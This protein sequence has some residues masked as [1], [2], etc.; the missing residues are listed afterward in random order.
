M[1]WSREEQTP[2]RLLGLL[3]EAGDGFVVEAATAIPGIVVRAVIDVHHLAQRAGATAAPLV[4][5]IHVPRGHQFV[6]AAAEEEHRHANVGDEALGVPTVAVQAFHPP[7][8][9]REHGVDHVIDRG[10]G[11]LHNDAADDVRIL[12]RQPQRHCAADRPAK[13]V[14]TPRRDVRPVTAAG[15]A[16]LQGSASILLDAALG[17]RSLG[18]AVAAVTHHEHVARTQRHHAAGST[19]VPPAPRPPTDTPATSV[20]ACRPPTARTRPR[21]LI[22]QSCSAIHRTPGLAAAAGTTA[23]PEKRTTRRP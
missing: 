19:A 15:H 8:H 7:Q 5:D 20:S 21:S 17:R 1:C 9:P 14:Q 10:E 6:A 2:P 16:V 22:P 13:H 18:H 4:Q 12:V 3:D 11:V 23:A